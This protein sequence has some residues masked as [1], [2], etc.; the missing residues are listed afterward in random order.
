MRYY[1]SLT[2]KFALNSAV[3]LKIIFLFILIEKSSIIWKILNELLNS[4]LNSNFFYLKFIILFLADFRLRK[5]AK[6]WQKAK[7]KTTN[8]ILT[9]S[10]SDKV[11]GFQLSVFSSQI[12][13]GSRLAFKLCYQAACSFCHGLMNVFYKSVAKQT[14]LCTEFS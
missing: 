3:Y 12:D 7:K 6:K 14:R 11:F 8:E 1:F 13:V 4:I 9:F 5:S 10:C 2:E